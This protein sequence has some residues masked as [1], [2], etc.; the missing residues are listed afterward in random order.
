MRKLLPLL[1]L[2][3]CH[4]L[5]AFPQD[6]FTV[7]FQSTQVNFPENIQTYLQTGDLDQDQVGSRTY[8]YLQFYKIPNS[9]QRNQMQSRGIKLLDY[10]PNKVYLASLPS[11]ANP[12]FLLNGLGIRS[13]LKPGFGEK[14]SSRL[15]AGDLP[16]YALNGNKIA[17]ILHIPSDLSLSWAKN[18]LRQAGIAVSSQERGRKY[19][20]VEVDIQAYPQLEALPY[21]T[22]IEP[23]PSPPVAEDFRG[24]ALHKANAINSLAPMGRKY[25]G[26]G[27]SILVRDDGALGPHIDF[28][29]RLN[30]Q[31]LTG[32]ADGTHGDGVAGIMAG[33]GNLDPQAQGMASGSDLYVS[34][35]SPSFIEMNN[36]HF[37]QGVVITNSSYSD[38]CNDG[39][40]STTET[41]EFQTLSSTGQSLLHVFSAGNSGNSDCG[42][43]AGA[44]WGNITGGHKIAKNVIA[45]ANL[46][47]DGSLMASSSRGPA[48]DGR[49]KPDLAANGN[50]HLSTSPGNAYSPFGGTSGAAPGVAG[51]A[52]QLYHAYR[53]LNADTLPKSGLIKAVMLNS[54]DD[55]GNKGPDFRFGW[56]R[57]NAFRAVRILENRTWLS[58]SI[59]QDSSNTHLLK[60]PAG[61]KEMRVMTYWMDPAASTLASTALVNDLN[62]KLN[63]PSGS[64]LDPWILDSNPNPSNLNNPAIRGVDSLNNVEQV[65][66]EN[67]AAGNYVLEVHGHSLAQGPQEYYVV[68]MYV[69]DDITVTHPIGGENLVPGEDVR[70]HWGAAGDQGNFIIEYSEDEGASWNLVDNQVAGYLRVYDW[71]VPANIT[72]KG[73]IRVSRGSQ[74]GQSEFPFHVL[75]IP[76][77]LNIIQTCNTNI[78]IQWDSVAGATDYD[79]FLLGA[80]TMDSIGTTSSTVFDIPISNAFADYWI[81]V[82]ARS[83]DIIGRRTVAIEQIGGVFNCPNGNDLQ[84]LSINTPLQAGYPACSNDVPVEITL[85]NAGIFTQT[86]FTVRYRIIGTNNT[87]ETFTDTLDPGEIKTY[88]FTTP[89]SPPQAAGTYVFRSSLSVFGDQNTANNFVDHTLTINGNSSFAGPYT[90]DFESY[91]LCATTIDCGGTVCPLGNGWTNAENGL[92]DSIDWRVNSGSTPSVFTGPSEDH[93]P[94][95]PGGSYLYLESSG[96]CNFREAKLLSPCIDIS[97]MT[98]P[99]MSLWYHMYGEDMGELHVDVFNGS[100][101]TESIAFVSGNQGNAWREIQIPL[102]TYADSTVSIQIRGITD[103]DFKG[104]MA[105]DDFSIFEAAATPTA[106]FVSDFSTVCPGGLVNFTDASDLDPNSWNW[107]ISPASFSFTNA[108]NSGS[109]NPAVIFQDYGFYTVSLSI[110]NPYGSDSIVKQQFIRVRDGE[111]LPLSEDFESINFPPDQWSLFNPDLRD[112]WESRVVTGSNGQ[113]S[114]AAFVDNFNYNASGSRD[115]LNSWVVDLSTAI[116]PYLIFEYAYARQ[117][118]TQS[119]ELEILISNNCGESFSQVIFNRSESALLTGGNQLSFW[120]PSSTQWDQVNL[121]LSAFIGDVIAIQFVNINGNGNSMF[122]DNILIQDLQ[123]VNPVAALTSDVPMIC[124]GESFTFSDTSAGNNLDYSWN[125]GADATPNAAILPGPHQ[126]QFNTPGIK[127]IILSI[128]NSSGTSIDTLEV[129]VLPEVVSAFQ[130]ALEPDTSYQAFTFTSQAQN[131]D[132]VSW[133]FGDG[134]TATGSPVTHTYTVN[135]NYSIQMIATNSCGND[136]SVQQLD[137]SNVGLADLYPGL[138]IQIQQ[139]PGDGLFGLKLEGAERIE[140]MD[141]TVM[142]LQGQRLVEFEMAPWKGELQRKV[143]L[144][145]YPKGIYFMQVQVGQLTHSIKLIRQ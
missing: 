115:G 37:N 64:S 86:N 135:G 39:Y 13:V 89:F 24:R 109:Q 76:Q 67:P 106:E 42:Y 52:T 66:I 97:G 133:D 110:S 49:I 50:N 96:G 101:W 138:D 102:D 51:V 23:I 130:F 69:L 94:G 46:D 75:S 91:T 144:R 107:S 137:I 103:I 30:S 90:E 28:Q 21:I 105:I 57:I 92:A 85:F 1:V 100:D 6:N 126:V 119:E 25:D 131:A 125:F 98:K 36:L 122:L 136:T 71:Q 20:E 54:A 26:E 120:T 117:T 81:A 132:Q 128:S 118:T 32:G 116:E 70:I 63:L 77:D 74:A 129:E 38:G 56:G 22:F 145:K 73:L 60:V 83:N 78:K 127:Q 45:T 8:R 61:V 34:R 79:V 108:T 31:F 113:P 19:I 35:Y 18:E 123:E 141:F 3:M 72:A 41:V 27:I 16:S 111:Q 17:L 114:R 99:T 88:R 7:N 12:S 44:R 5:L 9:Q 121:D 68:Y 82:R 2:A 87:N 124:P 84:V 140:Q 47:T 10:I 40:T 62:T 11:N 48:S 104:D 29:G 95:N 93:A 53:E 33:S 14:I 55:L 80:V 4:F 139:N 65:T 142:N 15:R 43:G 112:T 58:S 59:E 143:D 134:T